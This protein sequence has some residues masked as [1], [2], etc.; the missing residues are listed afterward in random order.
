MQPKKSEPVH[1]WSFVFPNDANPQGTMFGG[2]LLA[3]MDIVAGIAAARHSR[4]R[5]AVAS[6]DSITFMAPLHV[7]DMVEVIACVVWTG[8][9]SIVVKTDVFGEEPCTGTRKHCISTHFIMIAIDENHHPTPV[10]PLLVETEREKSA[11]AAAELVK[12]RALAQRDMI[13][14]PLPRS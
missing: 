8:K 13:E 3:V 2:K 5:V 12:K 1:N 6:I 4:T 9:T 10:P 7:G 14:L 11:Y